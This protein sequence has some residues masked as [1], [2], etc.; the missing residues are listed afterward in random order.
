MDL[1]AFFSTLMF[2]QFEIKSGYVFEYDYA[3]KLAL[4]YWADYDAGADGALIQ[5]ANTT[6]LSGV[7]GVR[8]IAWGY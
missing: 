5:V 4:A 3:N 1:S 8:F 6:D 7:T 2:V